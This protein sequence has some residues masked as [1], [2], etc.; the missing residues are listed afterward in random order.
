[1]ITIISKNT[2]QY[3]RKVNLELIDLTRTNELTCAYD[4]IQH[5]Q[6]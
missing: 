2:G 4:P 6:N 3:Q 1:M 5:N